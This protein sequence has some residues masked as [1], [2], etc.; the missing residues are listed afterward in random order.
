MLSFRDFRR[1]G[2]F[3]ARRPLGKSCSE[4]RAC[5]RKKD[6]VKIEARLQILE[7]EEQIRAIENM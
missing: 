3:S 5:A 7:P 1:N 2:T 6:G 4:W